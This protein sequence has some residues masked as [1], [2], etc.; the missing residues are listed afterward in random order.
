MPEK[1]ILIDSNKLTSFVRDIFV[2]LGVP[3][4]D[5]LYDSYTP[6]NTPHGAYIG[7]VQKLLYKHFILI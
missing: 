7:T 2:K 6:Q 1:E 3:D 5:A 4:G